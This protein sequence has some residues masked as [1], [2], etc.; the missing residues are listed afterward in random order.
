MCGSLCDHQ[1]LF[2]RILCHASRIG[3]FV[4][5][6]ILLLFLPWYFGGVTVGGGRVL[7]CV[8]LLS[9]VALLLHC[10][11]NGVERKWPNASYF[12]PILCW[13]GV[14]YLIIL[15]LD[16]PS[17]QMIPPWNGSHFKYLEHRWGVPSSGFP[18]LTSATGRIYLALAIIALT[19]HVVGLPVKWFRLLLCLLAINGVVMGLV[20][21]PFKYSGEPMVLGYWRTGEWYFYSA[22]AY[23]NHW[24]AYALLCLGSIAALAFS[25]PERPALRICALPLSAILVGTTLIATARLG[26]LVQMAV[27]AVA[28][29]YFLRNRTNFLM[30]KKYKALTLFV[31]GLLLVGGWATWLQLSDKKAGG[32]RAWSALITQNPFTSRFHLVEDT[33][34]MIADKP[35]FGWGLGTFR[36]G[37][38]LYQ[39]SETRIVHNEGRVTLY[40]HAHNDWIQTIA[41]V[42]ILGAFLMWF[43]FGVW[44][45]RARRSLR[46]CELKK[47]VFIGCLAFLIM[48]FAESL[49]L[50]RALA[51]SFFF[52]FGL[53]LHADKTNASQPGN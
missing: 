25:M 24:G 8:G 13:G 53:S 52:L 19:T 48:A 44:I 31:A 2:A 40:N 30:T 17:G 45:A 28:F 1:S 14:A 29:A 20:G 12:I 11:A 6:L 36:A 27:L 49:M 26:A 41:E 9:A 46:E 38:R 18:P 35:I 51:G 37:F 7:F 43:P 10:I 50:N 42:G 3:V 16:N 4:A 47:W 32:H 15:S 5:G 22:F 34:P 33:L 23:H 39:R 21:I